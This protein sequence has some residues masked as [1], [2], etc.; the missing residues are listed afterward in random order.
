MVEILP[1]IITSLMPIKMGNDPQ[2]AEWSIGDISSTLPYETQINNPV[3][4]MSEFELE[5]LWQK[6]TKRLGVL[7]TFD[8]DDVSGRKQKSIHPGPEASRDV[9][10][11]DTGQGRQSGLKP[12]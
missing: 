12:D 4:S 10:S 9:F 7:N 2:Q 5:I 6:A 11:S 1:K 3:T 8:S